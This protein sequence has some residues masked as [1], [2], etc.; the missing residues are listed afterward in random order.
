MVKMG[1]DLCRVTFWCEQCQ[2]LQI[3]QSSSEP[4]R[5]LPPQ[6][7]F[8]KMKLAQQSTAAT[9]KPKPQPAL[10]SVS[11]GG[12]CPQHGTRSYRIKRV[13]HKEQNKHRL[14]ATCGVPGC[15]YFAWADT[16]LPNCRKCRKKIILR[17][18][19]KEQ[20]SGRWFL[21]CS[22]CSGTFAWATPEQLTPLGRFLTPLL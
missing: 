21:S 4:L 16:H 15:P 13:R 3:D 20:S 6:N 17:V 22:S 9:K 1:D 8:Q 10:G 2:P 11:S 14:F 7:A 18:S 19:K 12:G 5:P